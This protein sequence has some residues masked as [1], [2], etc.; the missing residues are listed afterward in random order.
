MTLH[1]VAIKQELKGKSIFWEG[2]YTKEHPFQN[3]IS[4]CHNS[5]Q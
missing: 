5:S 4:N 2:Y 3:Y 1:L